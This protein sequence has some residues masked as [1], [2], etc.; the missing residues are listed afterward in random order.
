MKEVNELTRWLLA[1]GWQPEDTPP[2]T[3]PYQDYDGGWT[4]TGEAIRSMVWETPCGLLAD[5]RHFLNGYMSYQGIDWRPENG[6]PVLCC[7]VF[8]SAPCPLRDPLLHTQGL[9][10]HSG[11]VAY[12]CACHQTGRPYTYEGSVDETHDHVWREADK[13]WEVFKAQH[14]G[15]VCRQQSHYGRT[16]KTWRAYYDPMDCANFG[17]CSYCDVLAKELDTRKGNVF[18]DLRKSWTVKGEGLFPDQRKTMVEKGHKL[19]DR[20]A[21]LTLCE[22]IVKYGRHRVE[23]RVRSEFHHDLFFNKS[24]EI[25]VI[26]LRAAR[27]DKRDILQDLQDVTNGIEVI[28]AADS[29]KAAKAQKQARREAAKARRIRKAEAMILAHGWDALEDTW[30]RRAEKLLDEDRID[31]LLRQRQISKEAPPAETQICLYA[32]ASDRTLDAA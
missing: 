1:E 21:S 20:T 9:S 31:E 11:D 8:P 19:L 15:R 10:C 4:Y 22:A 14:K 12:Q 32:S 7:P 18:Y 29:L 3:R 6:N 17:C 13:L 27:V 5:G 30:K 26:N 24:L 16:T 28:H 2:G 23:E 25:E